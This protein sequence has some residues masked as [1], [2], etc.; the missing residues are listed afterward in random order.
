MVYL[1]LAGL[2]G[3]STSLRNS[4]TS[5][6]WESSAYTLVADEFVCWI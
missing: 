4:Q 5:K 1:V 3:V 2:Y 6:F